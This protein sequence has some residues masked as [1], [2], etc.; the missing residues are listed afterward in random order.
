[1]AGRGS[2]C[3]AGNLLP[4]PIESDR[5]QTAW[6]A[7]LSILLVV[8]LLMVSLPAGG[9][10][11]E[12]TPGAKQAR[13][14]AAENIQLKKHLADR[15]AELARAETQHAQDVEQCEERLAACQERTENLQKDLQKGIAERVNSVTAAVVDENARLRQEIQKLRAEI[16]NLEARLSQAL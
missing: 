5:G 12:K 9:C 11:H 15:E 7:G 16:D 3:R 10:R 4:I 13:L 6:A 8:G 1:M 14:I 2:R